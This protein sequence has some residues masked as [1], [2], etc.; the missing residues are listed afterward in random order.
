MNTRSIGCHTLIKTITL[1]VSV[2][3]LSG[4]NSEG[5]GVWQGYAWNKTDQRPEFWF[6]LYDSYDSCIKDMR[7][8]VSSGQGFNSVWYG[9]PVGC[10]YMSNSLPYAMLNYV[11][12]GD[13]DSQTCLW[14]GYSKDLLSFNGKYSVLLAGYP[15][16]D[17]E[18]GKCVF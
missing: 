7:L 10:S 17:Q 1:A 4:C 18:S 11:L 5:V 2:S 9:K 13:S 6:T 3:L 16:P 15:L 12:Y 8:S 14:E